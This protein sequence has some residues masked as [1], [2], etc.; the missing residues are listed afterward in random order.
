MALPAQKATEFSL[1]RQPEPWPRAGRSRAGP[2]AHQHQGTPRDKGD[3][4]F[5][6]SRPCGWL[7]SQS[8]APGPFLS[9]PG[10]PMGAGVPLRAVQQQDSQLPRV[11]TRRRCHYQ[12]AAKPSLHQIHISSHTS[13][14]FTGSNYTM[15]TTLRE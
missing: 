13:P 11:G 15:K 1:A 8:Q 14:T 5:S 12:L 2:T 9:C 7:W 10:V 4:P 3:A 6:A